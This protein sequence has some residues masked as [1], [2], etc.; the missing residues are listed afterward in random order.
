MARGTKPAKTK[1]EAKRP[2]A[3]RASGDDR[4]KMRALAVRLAE[5]LD[6]QAAT[7]EILR[8]M[9][10]SPN[11]VQPVLDAVAERAARLCKAPFARVLLVDGEVLR[12][13]AE[14]AADGGDLI[15]H[16]P[17]VLKRSSISG[18]AVLDGEIVHHADIVPLVDAEFPDARENVRLT[19]SRAA[20]AVPL[21]RAAGAVGALYL[22]RREPGLFAPDQVALVQTF[23][24]QAAIAIDSVRL[25][26]ETKEAL[27]QQTATSEILRA[28]SRSPTDVKPVFETIAANAL[29]LCDATFSGCFS[30]DGELIRIA[31]LHHIRPEG[32]PAFDA[33]YPCPP[34]RGGGTQRAILTGRLVHIPDIRQDPEYVYHDTAKNADYRSVLAVPML[35]DGRTIGAITVY[36]DTPR[37]FPAAQIVLLQ[38]FAEQAVIAVENVHLFTELEARN[39]DL[40]EALE[41]QTATSDILAAIANSPADIKPIL[42]TVVQAAARYCGAPDVALLRVD[43]DLLR[44]AA[45]VG[46]FGDVLRLGVGHI[47]ALEIPLTTGSVSGRATLERRSVHVHDLAAESEDEYPMGR[48]LQRRFGHRT[49]LAVPL[50]REGAAIGVIA[51]FRTEVKPFA[52]KQVELLKTFAD[53]AVIAIENARLFRDL[54]TRNRD[55]TEA[56]EQQTAT[57]EILRVISQSQMD[58]QPVFDTIATAALKLCCASAAIV[59]TFDGELIHLVS[60]ANMNPEGADALRRTYPRP[61]SRDTS[62]ARAI[63]TRSIT[64]I[65]DVLLDPDYATRASAIAGDRRSVLSIPLMRE[66]NPIGAI[67]VVKPEPGPFSDNQIALLQTF[68]DQAVIAI[69][70]ARLFRELETRNR[71]LTEALEQ[72]TATSEI[73]RVISSSPTD[74]QPV[75]DIIA[76]RAGKLCGADVAVVSKFDG[77][78]IELAAIHGL[79]PEGV[80]VVRTLFPMEVDA[81]T[82]TARVIRGS[83]VVH[84]ADV[85][86]EQD[87]ALKHFAQAA[88]YQAAL[89]VPIVRNRK[90]IG[91]IFVGRATPGLFADSQVALLKTFADQAVIAIENV[92]LFKELETRNRDLT[93]ALE[94]QT[95]TGEILRVISGSPTDV[96]PVFD[97]I[98]RSS[99]RLC[100]SLFANVFRF[101]GELLHW[102]SSDQYASKAV[103]IL[104]TTY[105][106][107][108]DVSQVSGRAILAK[109]IVRIENALADPNYD[110]RYALVGEWRRML[111]V[112]MLREGNPIGV[113][114]VGLGRT[115]ADS[116]RPRKDCS[117]PS[118][119]RRSSRSKTCGCSPNSTFATGI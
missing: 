89:G 18:R 5:A 70:N 106:M 10:V 98:A 111:G 109:A 3:K 104:R 64:A 94:Q 45:A 14:F 102:V 31:A 96:Q 91:S 34:S 79:V 24:R 26:K 6:Q 112:P 63:L 81:Q 60:L 49:M 20:L 105:P 17:I 57:S 99:V 66:G 9:A 107:R 27:E 100:D 38:T 30:Y 50:L 61:P 51:L 4:P 32:I 83:A 62:S 119:T 68:A 44:G 69:E 103:D 87:Y 116:H 101:D 88:Q 72:Q 74:V 80:K 53:Q 73:L 76:Q 115:R 33:A 90:V 86:A 113:I 46:A 67:S 92:R 95:A 78:L 58:A 52:D 85:F 11:D 39:H 55:L 114:V 77:K 75:F 21:M 2:V 25:F 36:R 118:P 110:H 84:I 117:R 47:E 28:I 93:E 22:W 97:A 37:P 59:V 82:V 40:A 43:G 12:S 1:V 29:R 23:A 71:D 16:V 108:P 65:P 48:E 42:E 56:L 13:M 8:V 35:R 19:G 7:S 41:R 54:E 15:S